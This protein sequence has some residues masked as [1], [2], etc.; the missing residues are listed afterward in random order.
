[1]Q[2]FFLLM[3][4]VVELLQKCVAFITENSPSH[5]SQDFVLIKEGIQ[6]KG[7]GSSRWDEMGLKVGV[8]FIHFTNFP[9]GV[10]R[11][12]DSTFLKNISPIFCLFYFPQLKH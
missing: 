5:E 12:L 3:V 1:M 2:V 7:L 6:A 8:F 4:I 10:E 9:R 11:Y